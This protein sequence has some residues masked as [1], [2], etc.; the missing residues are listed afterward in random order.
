MA[1]FTRI[2]VSTLGLGAAASLHAS[3]ALAA[4]FSVPISFPQAEFASGYDAQEDNSEYH[5]WRRYRRNRVDAGDVIAGI[6]IIGGIAA[7][8]NAASSS[9]RDRERR[10]RDYDYDNRD[11]RRTSDYRNRSEPRRGDS[12]YNGGRGIDGAVSQCVS[13]IERDVRVDQVDSV[14]RTA[15]GWQV[16][17]SIYNGERFSCQIGANGKIENVSYGSSYSAQ[18]APLQSVVDRQH[19]SDRYAAAWERQERAEASQPNQGTIQASADYGE[20]R[21]TPE[22]AQQTPAYPGGPLP[23]EVA[24]DAAEREVRARVAQAG[25]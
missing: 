4:E 3:P 14:N 19:S 7:I 22:E 2:F 5:R 18:S 10:A 15:Q 16:T 11:Y 6:A 12:R 13:R 1:R 20:P 21:Y 8:A 25:Q 23:G 17:G 24:E 9:K